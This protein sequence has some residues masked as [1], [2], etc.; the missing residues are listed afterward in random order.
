MI[1]IKEIAK[2][3]G[4][5]KS[6][7]ARALTE[8]AEFVNPDTKAKIRKIARSKGYFKNTNAVALGAGTSNDIGLLLPAMFVSTFYRDFYQKLTESI[9]DEANKLNLGMRMILVRDS[10]RFKDIIGRIESYRLK[11]L[12]LAPDWWNDFYQHRNVLCDLNLPVVVLNDSIKGKN[13]YSVILD[14]FKGGYTG[15]KYLIKLGHK[16]IAIYRGFPKDMEDRYNGYIKAMKEAKLEINANYII[17]GNPDE[18]IAG[19]EN[20]EKLFK[21]KEKP[22]AIFCLGDDM[23]IRTIKAIKEFGYRCPDDYSVLGY[24]GIDMGS[25]VEP[26]LTTMS[27]PVKKMGRK[28]VRLVIDHGKNSDAKHQTVQADIVI[29]SSCKEI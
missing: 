29:R 15:T 3:S 18:S 26:A 10:N 24:D 2:K 13:M 4:F 16:K 9:L 11:G 1:T 6:T 8:P 25:F 5:S 23:A 21:L 28:A 17:R 27:R 20:T 7:V 14:D 22:T 19:Y 12:I